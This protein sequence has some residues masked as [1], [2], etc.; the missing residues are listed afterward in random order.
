MATPSTM[1]HIY[2]EESPRWDGPLS[3][4][5]ALALDGGDLRKDLPS[6]IPNPFMGQFSSLSFEDP[7]WVA[8]L[9]QPR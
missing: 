1:G 6:P 9:S 7:F 4:E 3:P 5:A 8:L 2:L